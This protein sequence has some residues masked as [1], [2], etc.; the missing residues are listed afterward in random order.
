MKPSSFSDL[1]CL[2]FFYIAGLFIRLQARAVPVVRRLLHVRS[3]EDVTQPVSP[4]YQN[5]RG[6]HLQTELE[7]DAQPRHACHELPQQGQVSCCSAFSEV[8]R[9]G[10]SH[11]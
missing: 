11:L 4:T 7:G 9:V 8:C 3:S 5:P 10:V 6:L 1:L 2:V